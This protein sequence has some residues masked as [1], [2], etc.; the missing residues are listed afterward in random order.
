MNKAIA[1]LAGWAG[2]L[3][4]QCA[5]VPTLVGQIMGQGG[6]L[7]PASRVI[8]VWSGLALYMIRAV[9]DNDKL[10]MTSNGIGLFFNSILMALIIFSPA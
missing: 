5:T 1:N 3:L 7:P 8:M 2:M 9:A 6:P 10:Y 4:L